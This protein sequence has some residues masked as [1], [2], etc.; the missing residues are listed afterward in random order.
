MWIFWIT[1]WI[2]ATYLI[3]VLCMMAMPP[4]VQRRI[5]GKLMAWQ[6]DLEREQDEQRERLKKIKDDHDA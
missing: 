1:F 2:F 3:L 4:D 5:I 6:I